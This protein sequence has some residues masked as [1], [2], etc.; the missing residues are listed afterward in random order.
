MLMA[1]LSVVGINDVRTANVLKN[2]IATAVA[3]VAIAIFVVKGVVSWPETLVM[4]AGAVT[5]G[6]AGGR[7]IRVLPPA[8]VR[9]V[10][11]TAG[12][13]MT[14]YYAWRDWF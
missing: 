13:V 6:Y 5:G 1:I 12:V 2:A 10:V 9:M 8:L 3:A 14:C 7:L 11:V 4:L